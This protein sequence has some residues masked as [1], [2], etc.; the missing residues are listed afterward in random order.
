MA[1]PGG[2]VAR[3]LRQVGD[4][5]LVRR[6]RDGDEATFAALVDREHGRLVRLAMVFVPS[7]AVA[8]EVAQDTWVAAINGL[9]RF[10]GRSSLRTW[11]YRIVVNRART[12]GVRETRT[13]PRAALEG[14]DGSIEG[15]SFAAD[16]SWSVPPD[17]WLEEAE[18]RIAA[19]E[20]VGRVR[21]AIEVLPPGQ[22]EVV[23]LRDVDGLSSKDVCDV[24]GVTAGNQRVLLHRGRAA[25]RRVLDAEL[26][27]A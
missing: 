21:N 3:T 14:D 18:D 6:L 5:E 20:M 22:R 2:G 24:L 15:E 25:V 7:R 23:T 8:E 17:H 27:S 1:P 13:V 4:E 9:D 16:G 12:T 10:E 11:L 26:R 19:A